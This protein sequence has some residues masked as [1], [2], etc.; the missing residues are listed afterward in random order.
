MPAFSYK[1]ERGEIQALSRY[2]L[3]LIPP[4]STGQSAPT[5]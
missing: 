2:V 4:P 3:E 5:P 1:L